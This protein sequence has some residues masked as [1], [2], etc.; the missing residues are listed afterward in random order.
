MDR[1]NKNDKNLTLL[2][3]NLSNENVVIEQV[4][5]P[6]GSNI[7]TSIIGRFGPQKLY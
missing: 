1:A 2:S 5:Q 7:L 3:K 6:F 4:F